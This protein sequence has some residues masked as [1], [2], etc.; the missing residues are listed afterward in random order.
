MTKSLEEK[1]IRN[2]E[3]KQLKSDLH[4]K[5]LV[6]GGGIAGIRAALDIANAGFPVV[7]V[8]KRPTIG[9]HMAQLARIFPSMDLAIDILT[10][11]MNE[12][13]HHPNVRV[14][15]LS[16]VIG[17]NGHL[18]N[19]HIRL[20]RNPR[21]VDPGKCDLCKER[22]SAQCVE[23]CPVT[24]P[25]EFDEGLTLRK[26]IYIPF[27]QAVPLTYTIDQDVCISCG[28]CAQPEVCGP[29]AVNLA[30]EE[31]IVEEDVGVVI[32]TTGYEL[33]G[34]ENVAEYGANECPDVITSLQFERLLSP[35]G[36]TAGIPKRPSDRKVPKK[37]A[38]IP[39]AGSRDES[40]LHHYSNICFTYL[41]KQAILFKKLVPNGEV[42]SLYGDVGAVGENYKHFVKRAQEEAGVNYI[43]AEVSR[44]YEQD[45]KVKILGVDSQ[46]HKSVEMEVDMVVLALPMVPSL[47]IKDLADQIRIEVDEYG[48]PHETHPKL[49]PV[50]SATSGIFTAGC[51]QT[52]M[53]IQSTVSQ[54]KAAAR[55]A[56]DVLT[57]MEHAPGSAKEKVEDS[58]AR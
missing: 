23:V 21:L 43:W 30:E 47:G 18:G 15:T 48:F 50:E 31:E 39:C 10:P 24:V 19:F 34:Q 26:A 16:E 5:A 40:H 22:G 44:I 1:V 7:L 53:D 52:P 37:I 20:K 8:E 2:K 35:E 45:G 11:L 33:Y 32:V 29:R 58:S 36:P 25:S 3:V 41:A 4:K 57:Q 12:V 56:L 9:G 6:I 14:F 38:L 54:A 46:L 13:G 49:R 55:K 28:K 51:A 27:P 42:Y 17:V